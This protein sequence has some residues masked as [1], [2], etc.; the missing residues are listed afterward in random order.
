MHLTT[1][2]RSL[3][4]SLSLSPSPSLL[5]SFAV[6]G[7]LPGRKEEGEGGGGGWGGGLSLSL[8]IPV[9][10]ATNLA[11]ASSLRRGVASKL[12]R[13]VDWSMTWTTMCSSFPWGAVPHLRV[14]IVGYENKGALKMELQLRVSIRPRLWTLLLAASRLLGGTRATQVSEKELISS[15]ATLGMFPL[16]LRVLNGDSRTPY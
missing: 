14:P 7:P 10:Q 3:S 15:A 5:H 11:P 8:Q 16:M 4:L 12:P 2:S 9:G 13:G 6:S 1:L